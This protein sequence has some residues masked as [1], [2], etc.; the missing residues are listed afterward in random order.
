M[1]LAPIEEREESKSG[2]TKPTKPS[3]APPKDSDTAS[4]Q[5]GPPREGQG[6]KG[7]GAAAKAAKIGGEL[8]SLEDTMKGPL[9]ALIESEALVANPFDDP[10]AGPQ[11]N[12]AAPRKFKLRR[13][14]K[15]L[16]RRNKSKVVRV[17]AADPRQVK[18]VL[19]SWGLA[20]AA[21]LGVLTAFWA[22]SP[23]GSTEIRQKAE[24]A[25]T[26]E[27]YGQAIRLYDEFLKHYPSEPDANE[28]A[29]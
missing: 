18:L 23:R 3:P 13:F 2:K 6:K 10:M 17:K 5:T 27:D 11:L 28:S 9:D 12:P 14:L 22:L 21:L 8:E 29:C 4:P 19:I 1:E 15:N 24:E 25:V 7:P 20:V 26:A 16:F